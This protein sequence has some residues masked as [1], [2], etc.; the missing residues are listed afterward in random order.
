MAQPRHPD[1][2]RGVGRERLTVQRHVH[3]GD[4][5]PG[6]RLVQVDDIKGGAEDIGRRRADRRQRCLQVAEGLDR[7]GLQIVTAD[8]LPLVTGAYSVRT[9]DANA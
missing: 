9:G 4:E 3:A 1:Q 5:F 2:G 7:L 6:L 8:Q